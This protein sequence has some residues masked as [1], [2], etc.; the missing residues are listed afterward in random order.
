MLIIN[1]IMY[2]IFLLVTLLIITL[3]FMYKLFS[4]SNSVQDN[5]ILLNKLND[6]ENDNKSSLDLFN[7]HGSYR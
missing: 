2:I 3:L 7:N 1:I 6:L 4:K 5:N